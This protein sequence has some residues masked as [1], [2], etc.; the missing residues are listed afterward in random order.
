MAYT[1]YLQNHMEKKTNVKI[2]LTSSTM[3]QGQIKGFSDNWIILDKCLIN[4]DKIISIAL[5]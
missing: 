3:L 4:T 1:E 5:V 2:F